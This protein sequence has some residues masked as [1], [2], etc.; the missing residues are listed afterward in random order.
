M[1]FFIEKQ[2]VCSINCFSG[3]FQF[4]SFNLTKTVIYLFK[5][6]NNFAKIYLDRRRFYKQN[7]VS[8]LLCHIENINAQDKWISS[9]KLSSKHKFCDT[10]SRSLS[11]CILSIHCS[12]PPLF[13]NYNKLPSLVWNKKK[14]RNNISFSNH[15]LFFSYL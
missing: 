14:Q 7:I 8:S 4:F 15:I 2:L 10:F 5:W 9:L 6:M 1:L 3:F 12:S 13:D 11:V